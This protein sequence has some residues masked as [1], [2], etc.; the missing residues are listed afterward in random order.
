MIN[1]RQVDKKLQGLIGKLRE[2]RWKKANLG[3][4]RDVWNITTPGILQS[5]L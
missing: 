1:S 5:R 2:G 4:G 3:V